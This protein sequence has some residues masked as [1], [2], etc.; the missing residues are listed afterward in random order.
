[1]IDY[2]GKTV[3]VTGAASGIGEATAIAL[4]TRGANVVCADVDADGVAQTVATAGE[5]AK[6]I[7]SDLSAPDAAAKLVDQAYDTAG[8]LD[9]I[10]S[11]AGIGHRSSLTK[12][13]FD[14]TDAMA[15]LFEINFFAGPKIAQAYARHLEADGKRGRL[16]VTASE[17][18]LSVP[19]AV[20]AGK[21][22]FYG[23]TKHALLVAME[24]LRIEQEKEGLLDLH[25]LLPGAVYTPLVARS[26][27]DPSLAPPELELITA[28]RCA[29]VALKG[30]D[31]GLFY[32]P[33][34]AHLL[35]DMQPRVRDIEASLKALE[36]ER[37]Y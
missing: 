21:M 20:S 1:M 3:L 23:A 30:M 11:N 14:A 18:S 22:T 31:L 7:I 4:A 33:T 5:G 13:P 34:Q 28:E 24:W 15:K 17:N 9:L 25:V 36:I 32:I 10:F 37:S 6:S 16:M 2:Q 26:L 8:H 35:D 29:E 27:P 19:S 12:E